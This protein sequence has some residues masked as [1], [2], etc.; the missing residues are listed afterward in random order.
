MS[1]EGS[2]VGA[3]IAFISRIHSTSHLVVCHINQL[4]DEPQIVLLIFF[5]VLWPLEER[6]RYTGGEESV[7]GSAKIS[8]VGF[9]YARWFIHIQPPD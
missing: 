4:N 9:K 7:S 1:I 3:M 8:M 5:S 2:K 6:V